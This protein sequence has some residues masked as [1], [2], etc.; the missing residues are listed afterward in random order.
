MPERRAIGL[1]LVANEPFFRSDLIDGHF[2]KIGT[3]DRG[4]K[5]PEGG[6]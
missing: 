3:L 5:Y 1:V 2:W 6:L 4:S